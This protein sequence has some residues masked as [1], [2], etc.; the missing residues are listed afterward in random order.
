[1]QKKAPTSKELLQAFGIVS[2]F[3]GLVSIGVSI[4][5]NRV[6]QQR[7]EEGVVVSA[8]VSNK[9]QEWVSSGRTNIRA[10]ALTVMFFEENETVYET[11][12]LGNG[13]EI[14]LPTFSGFGDFHSSDIV[15]VSDE[16]F[17]RLR[18]G[19]SVEIIYLPSDPEQAWL[20]AEVED[21]K[22]WDG[23]P[24]IIGVSVIG[25]LFLAMSW[26]KNE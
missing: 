22:P 16:T 5:G 26:I 3:I 23:L 25:I 20:V 21:V 10:N 14:T 12:D 24:F 19:D 4:I 6:I 11:T 2:I 17:N 9:R 13:I 15:R 18:D 1:M 7:N 8:T